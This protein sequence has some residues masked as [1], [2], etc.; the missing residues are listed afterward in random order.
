MKFE[1]TT[2]TEQGVTKINK[3][4]I[5]IPLHFSRE[6]NIEITTTNRELIH[7]AINNQALLHDY[8]KNTD[9][10]YERILQILL[11]SDDLSLDDKCIFEDWNLQGIRFKKWSGKK[12]TLKEKKVF[13]TNKP[14][15]IFERINSN[16]STTWRD[17]MNL[18]SHDPNT[19]THETLNNITGINKS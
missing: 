2:V 1:N 16:K 11:R 9:F 4:T 17:Y 19:K 13:Y 7:I 15:K 3:I 8:S 6:K 10:V 14:D 12:C 5:V 18:V